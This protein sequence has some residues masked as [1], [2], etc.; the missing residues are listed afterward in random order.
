MERWPSPVLQTVTASPITLLPFTLF[1]FL[2]SLRS[3]NYTQICPKERKSN[4]ITHLNRPTH[5]GRSRV[6]RGK[7]TGSCPQCW[8]IH[9]H[10]RAEG[11]S[12]TH[13]CLMDEEHTHVHHTHRYSVLGFSLGLFRWSPL[14]QFIQKFAKHWP[15]NSCHGLERVRER[16]SGSTQTF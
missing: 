6:L 10:G 1:V 13:R 16:H 12:R 7:C 8:H 15:A 11:S 5:R 4:L 3:S 2:S 9:L 14:D